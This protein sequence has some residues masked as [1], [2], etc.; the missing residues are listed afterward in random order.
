MIS[1]TQPWQNLQ[2][3]IQ[4]L[5]KY[6]IKSLFDQ[7]PQRFDKYHLQAANIFLDYSK[8]LFTQETLELLL[9]L[10]QEA[11]VKHW[12]DQMF[13]GENINFTENRPALHIALRN[14]ANT[15]IKVNG[16]D[17]MPKV[18]KVLQQLKDFSEKIR[19]GEWQGYTGKKIT[20]IVNIGIGGS[21]LGPRM[22]T[23]ALIP[24]HHQRL[25]FHFVSNI[26]GTDIAETI[27]LLNP[28]T[29][30]FIIASKSFTT[31][32]TIINA[33]TAKNWFLQTTQKKAY[34]AKHFI[35]I[36]TNTQAVSEFGIDPRNMF[37]FWDWVGGRY[38]IWSAIGLPVILA[39]GM[40]NFE[41]FL[42][43]AHQMD[44]HFQT[45]PLEKN[46]PVILAL[47][48]ILNN[49]FLNYRTQ[50]IL[51]YDQYLDRFPAYLQQLEMESN[52]KSVNRDGKS[53]DYSTAPV[54]WGEPG[55]N[56]QH[57]FHQLIHQGTQIIPADFIIPIQ[58]HNP[59][60]DHHRVLI[61][62]FLAQTEALM[63]G[64]Q[65]QQNPHQKFPGNRPS[66]SIII[67][68][69]TPQ[70]LGS[71]MTLYEHK[72]FTQGIIWQINS[73]DQFGVELG[74]LLTENILSELQATQSVNSHNSSTNGL[75]NR[76][77][78]H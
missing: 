59:I 47:I 45:T 14:R 66:N 55:T 44:Q 58:S 30:L 42:D 71:L 37:Q 11:K 1:Q 77:L 70:T 25:K 20:D 28:Q 36:S 39:I 50:A 57:S 32:E 7:D 27:K 49:N 10:A 43:G 22:V 41:K 31:R 75:I 17:V 18:N 24:Y 52:G 67:E 54:I 35:A 69:L 63:I 68:K 2:L 78:N 21:D 33:Q 16:T 5:K 51:P 76:I 19:S 65:D 23:R 61:S 8:N 9:K 3:H 53:V 15:S 4:E 6:Q 29:T 34:I 60:R 40:D 13:A 26:D 38:S 48:G 64:K 72:V 46:L 74:K 12:R 62:N 73:F 56:G